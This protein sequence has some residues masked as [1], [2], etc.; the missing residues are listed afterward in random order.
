MNDSLTLFTIQ[1]K[2]INIT[3]NVICHES[4]ISVFLKKSKT[5]KKEKSILKRKKLKVLFTLK[6][7]KEINLKQ[8]RKFPFFL[9]FRYNEDRDDFMYRKTYAKIDGTVLEN[10]AKEII[11][12]YKDYQYYIAVVKNN[13]Y[14]H[15]IKAVNNLIE[16]GVN[17]LAVS[18]LDEAMDIRKYNREI[19]ILVLEPID[20]DF[21]DD[22]INNNVTLTV[23]S[24]DYV[25][26]LIKKEWPYSLKIHIKIDTGMHRLGFN[27]KEE[28]EE[29]IE[30]LNREK[31]I[32]L[33][34]IY[35]HLATSG[36]SD[37]YYDEQIKKFKDLTSAIDL[38]KIPIIHLDRSL[39]LVTHE[40]LDFA[41][42]VRLVIVLFGFN[43]SRIK[44]RGLKSTL[45]EIKRNFYLKHHHVSQTIL[46]N[47]LKVKTAFSLYSEVISVRN[48][49][50]GE[51]VGYNA[52]YKANSPG[53]IATIPIGFGDGVTKEFGFVV[54]R[55]KKYPIIADS[56]DMIM[57][58]V[59][60]TIKIK[61]KVEIFGDT[62]SI[63]EVTKKTQKNAYHLFNEIS[64]RVPRIHVENK[65]E[66]EIKY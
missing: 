42:G 65:E 31:K 11:K 59:D 62:I 50:K 18:S 43:G 57:V 20:I 35:T 48:I 45:R 64:N 40:K 28:I 25:K 49:E 58:L 34:G 10:N 47:N 60:S 41:N 12:K 30:L 14:H 61:D 46:E 17:Y 38:K 15:G 27:K 19:P 22:A 26:K 39:T 56:M 7:K 33:E 9:F 54:I 16:G 2:T 21:I 1:R 36:I 13:A 6:K 53:F 52:L 51:F 4:S 23:E 24:L 66:M 32:I 8:F 63:K 29:T 55:K 3:K 44:Q 37:I 5:L